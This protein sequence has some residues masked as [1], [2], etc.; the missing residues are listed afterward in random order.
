[1]IN[2]N[3]GSREGRGADRTWLWWWGGVKTAEVNGRL[4]ANSEVRKLMV[5]TA[6]SRISTSARLEAERKGCIER[7]V[8]CS[9]LW[10]DVAVMLMRT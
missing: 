5:W 10:A 6:M 4:I 1:V 8:L 2:H 7:N 9:F 3:D